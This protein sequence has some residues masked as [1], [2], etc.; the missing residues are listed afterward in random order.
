[1]D[2]EVTRIEKNDVKNSES[3]CF[4]LRP[5]AQESSIT[6]E[7][8]NK[9]LR[10]NE[11]KGKSELAGSFINSH[12]RYERIAEKLSLFRDNYEKFIYDLGKLSGFFEEISFEPPSTPDGATMPHWSNNYL[13]PGDA[14]AL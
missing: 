4:N 9:P 13:P 14:M 12:F 10:I 8:E 3:R 6:G 5:S 7:K 11:T 1:M 2:L